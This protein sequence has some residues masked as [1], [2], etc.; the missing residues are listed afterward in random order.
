MAD[1][2]LPFLRGKITSVDTYEAPQ[3]GRGSPPS[4]PSLDP[5]AHR[6]SLLQQLDTI[7]QQVE[8]RDENAR[9]ELAKR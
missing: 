3:P 8:A 6:T 2:R 5:R 9:D 7:A 4:M 1:P